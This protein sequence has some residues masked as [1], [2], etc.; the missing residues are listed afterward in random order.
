MI[1]CYDH[2]FVSVLCYDLLQFLISSHIISFCLHLCSLEPKIRASHRLI[3]TVGKRYG[4]RVSEALYDRLNVYYFV[5]GHALNDRQLLAKISADEIA[6]Q[7]SNEGGKDF[8]L[9][10]PMRE[11]AILR[12]LN[13]DEGRNE[14]EMA[15]RA[16]DDIGDH[17]IPKFIVE[18]S[19][20]V[21]GA[22]RSDHFVQIFRKIERRGEVAGVPIFAKILGI[23]DRTI[24]EG[25]HSAET[26]VNRMA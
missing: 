15:L 4:L 6:K 16:L 24:Q 18:G 23:D 26:I 2:N 20:V 21:D 22:A 5:D 11:D 19:T 13:G 7:V 3:Q 12:F 14:I 10:P 9:P 17:G 1:L 25:S 8:D